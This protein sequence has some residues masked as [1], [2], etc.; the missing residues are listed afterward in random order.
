[1]DP[2]TPTLPTPIYSEITTCVYGE[3][4]G[5]NMNPPSPSPTPSLPTLPTPINGETT[6]CV[7]GEEA[8]QLVSPTPPSPTPP[9][10]P[11][12]SF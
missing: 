12:G 6:T 8:G 7:H 9:T 4:A 11:F 5:Q 2:L 3:E 1:M 10:T